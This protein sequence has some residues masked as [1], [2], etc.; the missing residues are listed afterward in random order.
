MLTEITDNQKALFR[1]FDTGQAV[2]LDSDGH[3]LRQLVKFQRKNGRTRF[4]LPVACIYQYKKEAVAACRSMGFPLD[5][6]VSGENLASSFWF[7]QY[8]FRSDY[9]IACWDV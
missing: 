2:V 7:V 3:V 1:E 8:D 9:A 5:H 6:V 4:D